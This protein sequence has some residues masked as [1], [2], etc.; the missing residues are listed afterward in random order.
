M[1]DQL[2]YYDERLF[3]F[4]NSLGSSHFDTFWLVITNK[5]TFIPLYA[6]LLFLIFKKLGWKT[7]LLILVIVALMIAVTDQLSNVFKSF[8][9]RPRPC[10]VDSLQETIRFIAPR[11]GKF[12]YFSAH[13]ASS[14]ALAVFIGLVLKKHFPKLVFILLFWSA[15][16]SYSRIYLGV[17]YPLDIITGMTI[18]G[19]IGFLFYKM[20]QWFVKKYKLHSLAQG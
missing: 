20:E 11:C 3:S 7:S 2:L 15:L 16:V 1:I 14:M 6:F 9:E 5:F 18:G 4:L 10:R 12:G 19:I 17:H 8:F 13:A